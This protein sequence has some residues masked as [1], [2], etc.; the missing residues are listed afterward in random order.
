ME[1]E[2]NLQVRLQSFEKLKPWF[3]KRLKDSCYYSYHVQMEKL[4][5]GYNSMRIGFFHQNCECIYNL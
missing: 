5:D 2:L 3:I 4:K 1:Q